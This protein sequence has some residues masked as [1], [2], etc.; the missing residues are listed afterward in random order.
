MKA[1]LFPIGLIGI[2]VFQVSWGE[3]VRL[4][5]IGPNLFLLFL[6]FLTIN[7]KP[8]GATAMGFLL[9]L[10]Q[11]VFS[12]SPLGLNAFSLSLIGFLLTRVEEKLYLSSPLV[13]GVLLFLATTFSG[14][15]TLF[16]LNFFM[17]YRPIL[18][19]VTRLILPEA[20]YTTLVGFLVMT[21]LPNPILFASPYAPRAL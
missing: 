16:N 11:D 6:F 18:D 10:Y 20:L 19:T 14:L 2:V 12:G 8:E 7:S 1:F 9:G 4:F 5:S 3:W 15:V 13:R 17:L 21:F